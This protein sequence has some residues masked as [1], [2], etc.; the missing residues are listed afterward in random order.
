MLKKFPPSL[1]NCQRDFH[2]SQLLPYDPNVKK[3]RR[4]INGLKEY[5]VLVIATEHV[6]E[7]LSKYDINKFDPLVGENA[8]Q[9]RAIQTALVFL[10]HPLVNNQVLSSKIN[11]IKLQCLSMLQ[12]IERVIKEGF[13][14][15]NLLKE[16]NIELNLNFDEI[17]LIESYLLT[18][19]KIVLPPR[20]ENPIVKN[21]Y[22]V[23][24]KIKE[25]SSVGST[26]ANK[27]VARLRQNL[28]EHSV[29]F[30]QEL[31]YQLELEESIKQMISADFVVMHR[32]LKCIPCFWTA[33]VITEAALSFGI[34]IVM[35]VQLKSKDRNYQ[36]EHEIYLYFEATS[37]KYQNVCPSSLQKE[38]PAI[39]LLGST[40]RDFSNLPSISDWTKEITTSGP[41]DLLLAYAAAHRQY[42]DETSEINI[43]DKEFEFY[44]KKAL[45]WGC[46]IQNSSR[47]FL[48]HAYC[49]HI[50]NILQ[51]SSKL[52]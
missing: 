43:Q 29:Q 8:C 6:M 17:F 22:T 36:L 2:L 15:S 30:V 40:C 5:L 12:D 31:A 23:T 48:S 24:K 7:M 16:K 34:P 42:P 3:E 11:R 14:L 9:I 4:L 45:E 21:E 20:Q 10:K 26:F 52:E 41:V 38:S 35:H 46:C 27:L 28:S 51:E 1:S 33:K 25:I 49:N 32:K 39:V 47:F 18:K 50:E 37:S 19:V 44:R 13:S